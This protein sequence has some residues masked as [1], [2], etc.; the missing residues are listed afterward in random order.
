MTADHRSSPMRPLT[1]YHLNPL[2]LGPLA[3][4]GAELERIAALGFRA[5]CMPPPL[6]PGRSGDPL[7]V[8]DHDRPHPA[9]EA[10]TDGTAAIA[11]IAEAC[12]M[13]GLELWLD[14]APGYVAAEGALA[15]SHP[16]W[17]AGAGDV[18]P[19]PRGGVV[20]PGL[21]RL[22]LSAEGP[23]AFWEARLRDWI[24]AGAS[25]FRA[26]RPGEVPAPAWGRL[27]A[28]APGAD[29]I[30][31]NPGMPWGEAA[32]LRGAGFGWLTSSVAWWNGR[33]PWFMEER[34]A[35][36]APL[37]GFPEAPFG[38]RAAMDEGDEAARARAA[39]L[40]LRLAATLCDAL[41]VPQ[42]FEYGA[43]RTAEPAQDRPGDLAWARENAPYDLSAEIREANALAARL[44]PLA[45]PTASG[46]I[47]PLT[48]PGAPVLA[49]LRAAA[50]PR[51]AEAATLVIANPDRRASASLAPETV[52]PGIGGGPNLFIG[53]DGQETVTPGVP[54]LLSPGEVRV[55]EAGAPNPVIRP[56]AARMPPE[57]GVLIPRIGI[58]NVTPLVE[59]GRFPAKRIV[60]EVVTVEADIVADTHATFGVALLW[61]PIDEKAWR[62][63]RMTP[64]GNDRWTASFPLERMGRH[65][66]AVEAWLDVFAGYRDEL[67]KKHAAGVPV[68][69]ELEEGRRH[70]V[71]AAA[72]P[73]N[74][75]RGLLAL[76]KSLENAPEAERLTALLAP[77]TARLMAIADN[78]PHRMRQNPPGKIEAERIAARF[79]SWYEIFPRSQSGDENRHG[80]LDDVIRQLPRV[81]AMGFDVLYFPPIH[82]IGRKNRKGR[83]NTLT[84]GP[85]DVGSPYAIGSEEG[86]HDALHPALGTIEDFHRLR[87]AAH[88]HGLELALD[89]AIQ[90]S[91]DHP[92]LRE[93]PEWFDWRPDGTIKYAENPPKKYEDIVNVDFY[94]AGAKPSLW[95]ALYDSVKFWVEQ[96]VKTFRVDNPHTKPLPFWEWMIG[97]IRATNPEVL[98]LSEAFTRPKVMYRLAKSGFSQSYTY[99]TWRETKADMAEYLTELSTTAPRDFFRPHFFV[100][101][102]D[103]NPR[104][105][106]TGGRPMHLTRAALAATLSGLWGVYQGFELCEATPLPGKEEYLDSEKYQIRVWP[107]RRPGDIVDEVTRLN[108]IRRANPA[109]QTH[110]GVTFLPAWN[111]NILY[112]E[113][114]T[115]DR[116]NVILVA[117]SMDPSTVQEAGFELPLWRWGQPDHAGLEAEDL[118]RGQR[119]AWHGKTQHMRLDPADLPFAI[120]R[121]RP[122]GA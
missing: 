68:T 87:D 26:L 101:T 96:G 55:L 80:T 121:V 117:V 99:F 72:R 34:A 77:E 110:L 51:V 93:H 119:F 50:D 122:L 106:Q 113:K 70:V 31:W 42:G 4:W 12:R 33:D 103:I 43:R 27:I 25:G 14:L 7:Q 40:S 76:A 118:M 71:A 5:V 62:E 32:A 109:L 38:P 116:S 81:R 48:G 73:G 108:A 9:L 84:P 94:A 56:D 28:A 39:A 67:S 61:R 17:F 18:L 37:I 49:V 10:G 41:L 45:G 47:R 111:D 120:W 19:D 11:A 88:A 16:E 74:A 64:L 20:P 63:V 95:V 75:R 54:L 13:A 35:L 53:A 59:G 112:Y 1:L 82:P 66:F 83:N 36:G 46:E 89:F 15:A 58:E 91:P 44:V 105:L 57:Q 60:G 98:F 79:A 104:H 6:A 22:N 52:L 100:N 107:D 97:E 90:C 69:L 24:G 92:W 85:D 78:R 86:G 8:A 29:F 102:P 30:A 2:L 3:G 114:A 23:L 115:E 21:L 65:V